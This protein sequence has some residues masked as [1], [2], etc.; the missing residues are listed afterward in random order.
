MNIL[1]PTSSYPPEIRSSSHL[2]QELAEGLRDREHAVTVATVYPGHN[3]S[4]SGEQFQLGSIEME[5]GIEVVRIKNSFSS[6]SALFC[7][8]FPSWFFRMFFST[9]YEILSGEGWMSLSSTVRRFLLQSQGASLR[10]F[11]MLS[12]Y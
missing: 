11:I 8:G 6:Q 2:M 4:G 12:I 5:N 1:L 7:Q 3:L 9:G 10:G